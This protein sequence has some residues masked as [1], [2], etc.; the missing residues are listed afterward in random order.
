MAPSRPPV[1]D[2]PGRRC[3][4]IPG[5][6]HAHRLRTAGAADAGHAGH[7]AAVGL[8]EL[9]DHIVTTAQLAGVSSR[10]I[11]PTTAVSRR[12]CARR[13]S[14]TTAMT[15]ATATRA[16]ATATGSE[17]AAPGFDATLRLMISAVV[18]ARRQRDLRPQDATSPGLGERG[19]DQQRH[20]DGHRRRVELVHAGDER[21]HRGERD[22]PHGCEHQ[23][24]QAEAQC[25]EDHDREDRG[26][27][28]PADLIGE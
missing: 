15:A 22:E 2:T 13:W 11:T 17:N 4:P 23:Q 24:R 26:R 16:C 21:E 8:V 14:T 7:A 5:R 28:H 12:A 19:A 9:G 25:D 27:D 3:P 18:A 1:P 6:R 20:G 10:A